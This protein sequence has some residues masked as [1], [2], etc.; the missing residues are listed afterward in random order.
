MNELIER[1]I[2]GLQKLDAALDGI[3]WKISSL[4]LDK[5][6]CFSFPRNNRLI[7]E[8]AE[9]LAAQGWVKHYEQQ[10]TDDGV[11]S[12]EWTKDGCGIQIYY[13]PQIDG[14][15]CK[16]KLLR[17]ETKNVPVYEVVCLEA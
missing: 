6:A 14:S 1:R 4:L 12:Q 9:T 16:L 15:S 17:T 8:N 7:H 13:R 5:E 3:P 10:F 11:L 2:E